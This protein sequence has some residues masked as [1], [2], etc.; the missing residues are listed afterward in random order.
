MKAKNNRTFQPTEIENQA[1]AY[2][3]EIGRCTT[4]QYL[5]GSPP[6]RV[7]SCEKLVH[8]TYSELIVEA[9]E[10]HPQKRLTLTQIY[11][12]MIDNVPS[13]G[14]N[15]NQPSNAGWKNCIRHN[16]SLHKVFQRFPIDAKNSFW[17]INDEELERK[18]NSKHA[19]AGRKRV[20]FFTNPLQPQ[21]CNK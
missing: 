3:S 19:A 8:K 13:C 17:Y 20:R 2:G 9:I 5:Y 10:S 18:R 15:A 11:K 4:Q 14:Q 6:V 1:A 12:W 16:L 21:G 7:V